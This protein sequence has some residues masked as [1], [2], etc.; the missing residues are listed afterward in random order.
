MPD[1]YGNGF[2]VR[3]VDLERH[4][5]PKM[6]HQGNISVRRGIFTSSTSAGVASA[7]HE[8][9]FIIAVYSLLISL[10]NFSLIGYSSLFSIGSFAVTSGDLAFLASMPALVI[11]LRY[12]HPRKLSSLLVLI[13]IAITVIGLLRGLVEVSV[14]KAAFSF[15]TFSLYIFLFVIVALTP[16]TGR[17]RNIILTAYVSVGWVL[18]IIAL[19]RHSIDPLLFRGSG[20]SDTRV[21]HSP[22]AMVLGQCAAF[23]IGHAVS[24]LTSKKHRIKYGFSGVVFLLLLISTGQRSASIAGLLAVLVIL[25]FSPF[26]IY[27]NS[28]CCSHFDFCCN[29]FPIVSSNL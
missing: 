17:H 24:N 12:A 28:A 1:K 11:S 29:Y 3:V 13:F 10:L 22:G 27:T 23:A 16:L 4:D 2:A 20:W 6:P 19:L 26:Q 14:F 5:A 25:W 21:L 18:A 7:R 8:F 15:R 9:Y